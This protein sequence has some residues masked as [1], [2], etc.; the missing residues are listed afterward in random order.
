M[1][2]RL[3]LMV[4]VLVA[5]ALLAHAMGG[6]PESVSRALNAVAALGPQIMARFEAYTTR[7][8]MHATASGP[9]SDAKPDVCPAR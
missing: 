5:W 7:A 4:L 1:G 9:A 2:V 8:C 3:Y 6:F